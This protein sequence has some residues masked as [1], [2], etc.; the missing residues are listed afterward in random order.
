MLLTKIFLK[1]DASDKAHF[2]VFPK[3]KE[4]I[5]IMPC[6]GHASFTMSCFALVMLSGFA[7]LCHASPDKICT[8]DKNFQLYN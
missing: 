8:K 6:F 5:F 3:E 7:T 4:G 1:I 2:E